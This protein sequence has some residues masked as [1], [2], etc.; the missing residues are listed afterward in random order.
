MS[1]RG[2]AAGSARRWRLLSL[3]LAIGLVGLLVGNATASRITAASSANGKAVKNVRVVRETSATT[4]TD[5]ASWVNVPNASTV[6]TVPANKQSMIIARFS[7]ESDCYD[8]PVG[9]WCSVRILIGGVEGAPASGTDFAFDSVDGQDCADGDGCWESHSMDRSRFG[10]L[11]PGNYTV[12]VQ[13]Q[14]EGA[15]TLR[16]DDWSLTVERIGL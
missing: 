5:D 2:G 8:G 6:V 10:P 4:Y 15:A 13:V 7:A 3:G 16:L 1:D 12:Q 9:D 11:G 14:I